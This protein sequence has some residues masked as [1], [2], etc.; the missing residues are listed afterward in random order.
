MF[1]SCLDR[2]RC[3][4]RLQ[5]TLNGGEF[6]ADVWKFLRL[7][8]FRP[9]GL[10]LS[11]LVEVWC[12]ISQSV[13]SLL[14]GRVLRSVLLTI[15]WLWRCES[16]SGCSLGRF[17]AQRAYGGVMLYSAK[18]A[19]AAAWVRFPRSS[20]QKDWSVS[21][22]KHLK[23]NQKPSFLV[24]VW[25]VWPQSTGANSRLEAP[26]TRLARASTNK[27]NNITSNKQLEIGK[28]M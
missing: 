7:I 11:R 20:M 14:S 21:D 4:W 1:G 2:V 13:L 3:E 16:N 28:G 12:W 9:T 5:C 18:R 26:G 6:V 19:L 10:A 17:C 22:A 23:T 25:S 24:Q 27:K 8:P 15:C